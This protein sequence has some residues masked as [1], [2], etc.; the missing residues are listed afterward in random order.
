MKYYHKTY[1]TL[2]T[3]F[4]LRE[5]RQPAAS[6]RRYGCEVATRFVLQVLNVL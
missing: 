6:R 2:K 1:K 4:G 5:A 3:M